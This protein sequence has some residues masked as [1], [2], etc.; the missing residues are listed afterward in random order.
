MVEYGLSCL[1]VDER[2]HTGGLWK[3]DDRKETVSI[4]DF[5]WTSTP[6]A[7]TEA[8]DFPWPADAGYYVHANTLFAWLQNYIDHFGIRDRFRLQH[9]VI[10]CRKE[11]DHGRDARWITEVETVDGVRSRFLSKFLVIASGLSCSFACSC[12]LKL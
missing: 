8:S 5:T 12:R 11:Q 3:F 9:R 4:A 7:F 6:R 2:S 1:C 10:E